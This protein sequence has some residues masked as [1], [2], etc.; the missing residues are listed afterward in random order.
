M[1][2]LISILLLIASVGIF[3]GY[4]NPT[5]SGITGATVLKDKSIAELKVQRDE[6][7]DALQKTREIEQVRTGLL[8]KYNHIP[9]EERERLEKLLPDHID[10]VR[11]IIEVNN[12]ASTYGMTLKNIGLTDSD[13]AQ[14]SST[15]LTP[16]LSGALITDG[17][18][19]PQE[20]HVKPVGLKFNVSG[21]YDNFRAFLKDLESNLRLV[22]VVAVTFSA[23][24]EGLPDYSVTVSTYRLVFN[25]NEHF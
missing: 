4:V 2:N 11:L 16:A 10:S 20:K 1:S 21:S 25:K 22:D 12:I 6:Y 19:G 24:K 18:I 5:Y 17:T 3:L 14:K 8:E 23:G 7:A 9:L 13:L 15:A